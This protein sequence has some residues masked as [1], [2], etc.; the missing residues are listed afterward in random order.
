[1][2]GK[3]ISA[4]CLCAALAACFIMLCLCP[5]SS[6]AELPQKYETSAKT[7]VLNQKNNPLCWAYSGSD[8][9]SISAIKNGYAKSGASVFSAPMI[10]RAEFDGN[11]HRYTKGKWYNSYGGLDYALFAGTTGKGLA[12]T[13]DYQTVNAA[14]DA[15]VSALYQHFAYIDTILCIETDELTR[16]QRTETIKSL[17]MEYGAVSAS[18]FVGDYNSVTKIANIKTFDNT[19]AAHAVLLVGWDDTKYTD[20]GTGAFLMKNTWGDGWGNGGYAWISY[21][22]DMGRSMFA[23]SV[24]VNGD[25]RVLSHTEIC[26]LSGSYADAKDGKYGAVNVFDVTEKMTLRSA[27]AYAGKKNSEIEINV[28]VN[29]SD[30]NAVMTKKPD[31]AAKGSYT[32]AGFYTLTLDR[33]LEVKPGDRVTALYLIK[34]DGKYHVYS[35]YSDP[36]FEMAVTSSKEGQSYTLSGGKLK[37]PKGN[38]I[39]TV[40]GFTEHTEPPVTEAPETK[41]PQTEPPETKP[42]VTDPPVTEPPETETETD[43]ETETETDDID[44]TFDEETEPDTAV[45]I[46]ITEHTDTDTVSAEET[47]SVDLTGAVKKV[48]KT[49]LIVIGVIAALFI[50][51]IIALVAASKK[52]KV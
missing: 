39:G 27:G 16:Q 9:L 10:A 35:E 22:S 47:S 15:P 18:L 6:A 29:L 43:F 45:I 17:I 1:M 20:T 34:S 21:N 3:R 26:N 5:V 38:Y 42:P 51:L 28:W 19:K 32:E 25:A 36:D 8:M 14:N 7:P 11:E 44:I 37:T 23:A 31:A 4:V 50:I 33:Q 24:T 30:T 52:K 41:P 2:V 46:P 48:F 40:I 13:Q 12:R 49:V